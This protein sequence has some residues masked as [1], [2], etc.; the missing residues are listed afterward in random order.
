MRIVSLGKNLDSRRP[1][2]HEK[3]M[4]MAT[5]LLSPQV[6]IEEPQFGVE[7]FNEYKSRF[8]LSGPARIQLYLHAAREIEKTQLS[9]GQKLDKLF[10]M[11]G[12][13]MTREQIIL[14]GACMHRLCL[15]YRQRLQRYREFVAG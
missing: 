6:R 14:I 3:I 5:H 8:Q 9:L 12:K 4:E 15:E 7:E 2:D 13:G 10:E 1:I 11:N